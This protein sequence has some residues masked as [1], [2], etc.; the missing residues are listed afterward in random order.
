MIFMPREEFW[1]G[2]DICII[3]KYNLPLCVDE[4]IIIAK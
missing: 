3:T 4:K 2:P 1:Y